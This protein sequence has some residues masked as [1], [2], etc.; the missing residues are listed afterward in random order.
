MT[1]QHGLARRI[2]AP[3]GIVDVTNL[4]L[5]GSFLDAPQRRTCTSR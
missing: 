3:A 4:A 2:D 5:A 1:A